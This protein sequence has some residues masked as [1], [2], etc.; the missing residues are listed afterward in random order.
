[1]ETKK[2][3]KESK[4]QI[5]E[6]HANQEY[7]DDRSLNDDFVDTRPPTLEQSKQHF[8]A[9]L[10]PFKQTYNRFWATEKLIILALIQGALNLTNINI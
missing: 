3:H 7:K 1:M 4:R 2:Q 6:E 5:D 8:V 9:L 10:E